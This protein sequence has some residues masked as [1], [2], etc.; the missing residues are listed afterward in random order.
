MNQVEHN[1]PNWPYSV[2]P[3]I[4]AERVRWNVIDMRTGRILVTCMTYKT[5]LE[6]AA[7]ETLV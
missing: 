1:E 4:I 6:F 5:A 7:D 2:Q 3:T